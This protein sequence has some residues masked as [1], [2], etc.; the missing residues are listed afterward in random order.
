MDTGESILRDGRTLFETNVYAFDYRK[1]IR[2]I[3]LNEDVD[4][5]WQHKCISRRWREP[6][7]EFSFLFNRLIDRGIGLTGD[8]VYWLGKLYTFCMVRCA[9]DG[10]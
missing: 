7:E 5:E 8:T 3:F 2:L 9:S 6:W 10:P 1:G 4:I